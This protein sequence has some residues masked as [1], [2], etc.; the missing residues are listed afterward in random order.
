MMK[1]TITDTVVSA[2]V[3]LSMTSQVVLTATTER[4]DDVLTVVVS[5]QLR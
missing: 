2:V 1:A 4:Y 3:R 5:R